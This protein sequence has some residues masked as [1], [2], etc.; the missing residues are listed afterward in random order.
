MSRPPDFVLIGAMK[1]GSTSL[2]RQLERHPQLFLS[3]PK[4]P[5][6]FSLRFAEAGA[7]AWYEQLFH[8]ARPGQLRGE[9]STGYTRWPQVAGVP[10]RLA[11]RSPSARLV[12]LLRDPVDRAVSHWRHRMLEWQAAGRGPLPLR[13]AVEVLPE[14]LDSSRYLRQIEVYLEHFPRPQLHLAFFEEIATDPRG[15]LE[16]VQRF[17]GVEPHP[18]VGSRRIHANRPGDLQARQ[19]LAARMGRLRRAPALAFVLARLPP[20]WKARWTRR[21]LD[22]PRLASLGQPEGK[23]DPLPEVGEDERRFLRDRLSAET[24]ELRKWLGRELPEGWHRTIGSP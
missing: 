8:G 2:H 11:A 13:E 6:Y 15:H 20:A 23:A 1:A 4:E 21:M 9:A 19:A 18:A 16:A 7:E 17:L 10:A 12:Y 14:I 5:E 22:S 3:R 24:R